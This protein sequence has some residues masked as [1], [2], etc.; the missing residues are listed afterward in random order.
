MG[1]NFMSSRSSCS[2]DGRKI[3]FGLSGVTCT[4]YLKACRLKQLGVVGRG[5]TGEAQLHFTRWKSSY[6]FDLLQGKTRQFKVYP[7]GYKNFMRNH[8]SLLLLKKELK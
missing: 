4:Y 5:A 8:K 1:I 3:L 2:A 7:K 6:S